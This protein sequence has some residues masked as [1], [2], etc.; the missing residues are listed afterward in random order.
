[1]KNN[2]SSTL[3]LALLFCA[4]GTVKAA[5][6]NGAVGNQINENTQNLGEV[7]QGQPGGI[8]TYLHDIHSHA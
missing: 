5:E 8:E 6:D 4:V 3:I 1:M 7:Y 2:F